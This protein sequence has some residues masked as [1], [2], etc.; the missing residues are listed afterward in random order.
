MEESSGGEHDGEGKRRGEESSG[1]E[2]VVRLSSC[3]GGPGEGG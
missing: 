2:R 3:T 1:E